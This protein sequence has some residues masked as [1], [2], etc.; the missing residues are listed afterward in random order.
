MT[1][2]SENGPHP[3]LDSGFTLFCD[4]VVPALS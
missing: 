4:Q 3:D 1:V 2:T